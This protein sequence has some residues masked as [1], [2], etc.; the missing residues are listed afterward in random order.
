[1]KERPVIVKFT[2]TDNNMLDAISSDYYP[3]W[4]GNFS[5]AT[6]RIKNFVKAAYPGFHIVTKEIRDHLRAM[7]LRGLLKSKNDHGNN[8]VWTLVVHGEVRDASK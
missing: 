1:M 5:M 6:W 8:I 2:P 4:N 3:D 7:M